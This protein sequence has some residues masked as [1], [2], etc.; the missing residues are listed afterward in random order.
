MADVGKEEMRNIEKYG[1]T[2]LFHPP[3]NPSNIFLLHILNRKIRNTISTN[4]Y[5]G[6]EENSPIIEKSEEHLV[7]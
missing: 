6:R 5:K 3:P 2:T 1:A 7:I 4:S